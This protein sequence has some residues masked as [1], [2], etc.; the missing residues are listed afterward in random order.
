VERRKPALDFNLFSEPPARTNHE[1]L[2]PVEDAERDWLESM[3]AHGWPALPAIFFHRYADFGSGLE[4]V[5]PLRYPPSIP[6][7]SAGRTSAAA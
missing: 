3:N 2:I 5:V 4:L 1:T 6:A 7:R